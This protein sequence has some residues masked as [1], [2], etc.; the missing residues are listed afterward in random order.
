MK[1]TIEIKENITDI[2]RRCGYHLAKGKGN[3][4]VFAR[5]LGGTKYPQFH[6]YTKKADGKYFLNLHLD[7]KKPSYPG[8]RAH[9]AEYGGEIIA[10]EAERI[11]KIVNQF[12]NS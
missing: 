11:K 6:L 9:S 10:E 2:I 5:R 1:F 12:F 7:Q 4:L 8:V 3:K